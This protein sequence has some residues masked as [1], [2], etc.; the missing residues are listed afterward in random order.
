[1]MYEKK[2][3]PVYSLGFKMHTRARVCVHIWF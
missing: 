3:V 2:F 1:M